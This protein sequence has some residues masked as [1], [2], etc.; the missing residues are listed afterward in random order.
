MEE[1]V[2][3]KREQFA[4]CLYLSSTNI[5]KLSLKLNKSDEQCLQDFFQRCL[6]KKSN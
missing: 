1:L 6:W 5:E 4:M 3:A 2:A